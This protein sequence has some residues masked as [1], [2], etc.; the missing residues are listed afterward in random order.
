VKKNYKRA[1][2]IDELIHSVKLPYLAWKV[3]FLIGEQ[4]TPQKISEILEE[5]ENAVSEALVLLEKEKM[6]VSAVS[7]E[8]K[9]AEPK[10]EEKKREEKAELKPKTEA[11]KEESKTEEIKAEQEPVKPVKEEAVLETAEEMTEDEAPELLMDLDDDSP[12]VS[13][14][15]LLSGE[16]EEH[17]GEE[18]KEAEISEIPETP[19]IEIA[20]EKETVVEQEKPSE[21]QGKEKTVI[22]LEEKE[23]SE[24][25]TIDLG[26]DFDT[27]EEEKPASAP[28]AEEKA[29]P[30]A[31]EKTVSKSGQ[32]TILVIDDSIVIRKMVEIAL[33]DADYHIESAV[34]GKAGLELADKVDPKLV[35]VDLMLPDING[36]DILKTIKASRGVPVIMLS[37]KDTPQMIEKAKAEGADEFLP[38]PFKDEELVEKINNLLK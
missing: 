7:E 29:A 20:D 35:I 30:V 4:I 38:K 3:L 24:D 37:G 2:N 22:E 17:L 10:V 25:E 21:P 23:D 34:N 18:T 31:E 16:L 5:S 33:E 28:A 26:I 8:E 27:P 36:I 12:D 11:A 1:E 15:D 13:E 9:K 19:E 14:S 32:A 6:V